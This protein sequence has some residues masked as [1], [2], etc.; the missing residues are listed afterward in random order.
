MSSTVTMA[1]EILDR[2]ERAVAKVRER[3]LRVTE[4]LN[5]AGISYAVVGG[6]VVASWVTTVDV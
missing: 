3:L 1:W 5:R 4:V 2:M 6:H